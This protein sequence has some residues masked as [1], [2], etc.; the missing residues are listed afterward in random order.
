LVD[1]MELHRGPI[2]YAKS[3]GVQVVATLN[4]IQSQIN[5]QKLHLS[6]KLILKCN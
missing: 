1:A 4:E 5:W 2:N 6:E 3:K